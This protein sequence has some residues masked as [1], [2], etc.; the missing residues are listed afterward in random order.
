MRDENKLTVTERLYIN[1]NHSNLININVLNDINIFGASGVGVFYEFLDDFQEVRNLKFNEVAVGSFETPTGLSLAKGNSVPLDS[2]I[3]YIDHFVLIGKTY[4]N[5]T[6]PFAIKGTIGILNRDTEVLNR[7]LQ[8]YSLT[9]KNYEKREDLKNGLKNGEVDY[10]LAP[11]IEFLD[12]VLEELYSIDYHF[13]DIKDYYYLT[14]SDNE[15]LSSILSKYFNEWSANNFADVFD[16]YEYA[17]FISKLK[18]KEK[19]L[20]AINSKEYTYGFIDYAPYDIKSSGTY[21]GIISIYLNKFSHFS[22]ISFNYK[23]YKDVKKLTAAVNKGEVDIFMDYYNLNAGYT[24]IDS[25]GDLDISFV[26]AN[27]DK[28]SFKSLTVLKDEPI[29]VKENT[30]M[31]KYLQDRGLMTVTYKNDDELKSVFREHHVVAMDYMG[32][33]LYKAK[34]ENINERF[35]IGTDIAY[36]FMSNAD[37]MFNRLLEYYLSTLDREEIIYNGIDSYNKTVKSSK[38]IYKVAEYAILL[39]LGIVSIA[40]VLYKFG[41]RVHIKKRIKKVDKMKYI[42]ILTSLKNRNF[43]NENIS[44][45]N[46]NTIYP[47]AIIVIDL[48]GIQYLNDTYGYLEGDKQIQALANILIKT[49]LDN[50]EIM[51]TDGNEFTVYLVGYSERQVLSYIKKLNKELKGLPHE[52]GAAIGFSM[53]EDDIKLV[54]DAINEATDMMK[55]NKEVANKVLKD[56]EQI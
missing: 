28:R 26:M 35:R 33:L 53:I 24:Q 44:V 23:E 22:G 6:S 38:L 7:Y 25:H 15:I 27:D 41:R 46:Q 56:E 31:S 52:K 36:N 17:M 47:Q 4:E 32:Y 3:F 13:T 20:D 10:I 39:V 2:K 37:T 12:F 40:F 49:Q 14:T 34:N 16:K 30:L 18:I 8:E 48:N 9:F 55:K 54:G 51:R 42:D 43:L 45:W 19:E 29:Y 5:T 21:G 50:T 11:N 1:D